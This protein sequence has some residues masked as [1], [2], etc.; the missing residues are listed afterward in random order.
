MPNPTPQSELT[1]LLYGSAQSAQNITLNTVKK[2]P[3][4]A[5]LLGGDPEVFLKDR[6]TGHI[7][8]SCDKIGGNKGKGIQIQ[9]GYKI[10]IL[11]DNVAV[12]FNF[13]PFS[14]A[15]T[16]SDVL[17]AVQEYG[18]EWLRARGF[19]P[20]PVAE[21]KF[22]ESQLTA[23]KSQV[24]GC[25]PDFVAYDA[26]DSLRAVDPMVVGQ[27]R[28]CGGHLHFG[29][30]NPE[31]IPASAVAILID[32]F[33][34]LPSLQLDAQ[35]ARRKWYGLAGLYRT[36][37]YGIEY[38]TM[39][40]WWMRPENN[41]Y[42]HRM[43]RECFQLMHCIDNRTEELGNLFERMPLKDIQVTLN[44]ENKKQ[45]YEVWHQAQS[46]AGELGLELGINF[47]FYNKFK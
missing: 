7:V 18:A 13:A 21:Y 10:S 27:H 33:V 30:T 11:E 37:P 29:Y 15:Y 45:G 16:G 8:P 32:M 43:F 31:K 4:K 19:D 47:P 17:R 14:D 34:G 3:A 28:F 41:E 12:E 35:G 1:Q 26:S 38:R 20:Y 40:N 36:K 23:P 25:D 6:R 42:A 39:S 46:Y 24:F 2:K 5:N 22:T 9:S 44:S